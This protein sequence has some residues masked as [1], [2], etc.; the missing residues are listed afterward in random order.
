MQHTGLRGFHGSSF[1]AHQDLIR[2]SRPY[3]SF[4]VIT[5]RRTN[6]HYTIEIGVG[7][8]MRDISLSWSTISDILKC[9]E[10][11][12]RRECDEIN[13]CAESL[14]VLGYDSK[15]RSVGLEYQGHAI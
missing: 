6:N 12:Q 7:S 1:F 10:D 8:P 11:A 13:L 4:F 9:G 5:S 2:G 14:C 3:S 15:P